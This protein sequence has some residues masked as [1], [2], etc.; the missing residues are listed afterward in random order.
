MAAPPLVTRAR[1]AVGVLF[2]SKQAIRNQIFPS[3][4]QQPYEAGSL[5]KRTSKWRPPSTRPN[6]HLWSLGTIRDRSRES[7]R[8]NG[9]GAGVLDK[10]VTNLIG[11]GIKPL[12]KAK[13]P[14]FRK[15]VND[16]FERWT[17]EADADGQ[18][19]FYGLQA[20]ATRG[21][22]EAGD[23]FSRLR[24]RLPVDGLTV[25]I[26]VQNLE[27]E[28]CPYTYNGL[29]DGGNRIRAGIEFDA[30]GRRVAYYFHPSRPELDD[31]DASIYRRVTSDMVMH[32]YVPLRAGQLRGLPVLTQ[33]LV[34]LHEL[35]VFD[36]ATL[37]RQQIANLFALFITR[38][39]SPTDF[40]QVDVL[41][42]KDI[43]DPSAPMVQLEPA[44]SQ[45]LN[46]GEDVKF[47]TPPDPPAGYADFMR[48]QLRSISVSTG[49]PYEVL[50]GDMT[51]MNDRTMRV[52]LNEFKRR[53]QMVQH[54]IL[55]FKFCRPIWKAWF[56]RAV[57]SGALQV[58]NEYWTNPAP[59]SAVR[60]TPQRWAYIHPVQDV[61]AQVA[62]M[63][64]GLASRSGI[65]SE[66]GDDS[67]QIDSE[68][69]DDN[70]RA[71]GYGLT[72]SSDSRQ[73]TSGPSA[74]VM[75]PP[76]QNDPPVTGANA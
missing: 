14:A 58:P 10:L 22:L 54:T 49:V 71:D 6:S 37:L 75:D 55:V 16:L 4:L 31:Y 45:E 3:P 19:D 69:R 50:T 70:V 12:S 8:N 63:R 56:D 17:D 2:G 5:A 35:D 65:V 13:D 28:F 68:Q 29:A 73:P 52:V 11:T 47:S 30:I 34:K 61:E 72:Y 41:T 27:S 46:P 43:S 20:Q 76:D 26:Q 1:D 32:L 23:A 36:D 15:Q 21:W 51:G 74:T 39:S 33:A 64:A 42:G 7:A 48:Q 9:Y 24:M 62:E 60:W 67:E 40:N 57:L 44:I 18:L 38:E 53:M 59:W 66:N 25:P